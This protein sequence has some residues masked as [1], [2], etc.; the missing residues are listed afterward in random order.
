MG[1]DRK[2]I[3][4][5][6]SY[7][8]LEL[9]TN[10]GLGVVTFFILVRILTKEDFG[11]WAL[12]LSSITMI[13]MGRVGFVKNALIKHMG[14]EPNNQKYRST[15]LLIGLLVFVLSTLLVQLPLAYFVGPILWNAPILKDL[16]LI[17][18]PASF[19]LIFYSHYKNIQQA[20]FNFKDS[21]LCAL[22]RRLPMLIAI[23][24]LVGLGLKPNLID[25]AYL[26]LGSVFIATIFSYYLVRK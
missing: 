17:N 2:F 16:F 10:Q 3:F 4:K 9:I 15:S 14:L 24:C 20:K 12:F 26:Q 21:W 5:A 25:L 1:L 23:L 13:E 6:G 8:S 18:I 11:Q 19:F 7:S 22:S